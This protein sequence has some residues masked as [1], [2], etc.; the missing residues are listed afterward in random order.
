MVGPPNLEKGLAMRHGEHVPIGRIDAVI[1]LS[2][3]LYIRRRDHKQTHRR[4]G[5]T[6]QNRDREGNSQFDFRRMS[7][8]QQ[9]SVE[10]ELQIRKCRIP[11]EIRNC[12][13][14]SRDCA[15][16]A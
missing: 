1:Y 8:I 9:P 4:A 15:T 14:P 16:L 12:G 7:Q 6:N 2:P 10:N 11:L 5:T 3:K 13:C